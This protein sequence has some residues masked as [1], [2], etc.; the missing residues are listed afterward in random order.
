MATI[1]A[2]DFP[3]I[4]QDRIVA[5][6]RDFSTEQA[7][8]D[9]AVAFNVARAQVRPWESRDMPMVNLY[10]NEITSMPEASSTHTQEQAQ[11]ELFMDCYTLGTEG[12]EAADIDAV[13]RLDYLREQ[14]KY[15]YYRL[16]NT[17]FGF[18]IGTIA[19]KRFPRIWLEFLPELRNIEEQI[20]AGRWA[21]EVEYRWDP[22]DITSV[23]LEEISVSESTI[24]A[25]SALYDFTAP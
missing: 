15:A 11:V 3:D 14:V 24:Q 10:I 20:V 17:D 23:D 19:R 5:A 7:A 6:L 8:I 18:A 25:W 13:R 22:E 2:R 1:I 16:S 12:A 21:V 4:L 9:P